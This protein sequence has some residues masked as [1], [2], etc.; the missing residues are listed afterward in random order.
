M[1]KQKRI[2]LGC[3]GYGFLLVIVAF[4]SVQWGLRGKT[5]DP[6]QVRAIS[7]SILPLEPPSPMVPLFAV[8]DRLDFGPAAIWGV[9]SRFQNLLLVLRAVAV[10]PASAEDLV[11]ELVRA[12]FALPGFDPQPGAQRVPVRVLGQER[13]ALIQTALTVDESKQTRSSVAFAA[14]G[15]WVLL[16]L[17]GDAGGADAEALQRLLDR[18]GSG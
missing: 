5:S 10:E 17:Q 8:S 15:R 9:D 6:D 4:V 16:M 2:L 14:G 7:A 3:L 1:E 12:H 18:I 11:T 13:T